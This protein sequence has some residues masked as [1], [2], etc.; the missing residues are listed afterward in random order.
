[1]TKDEDYTNIMQACSNIANH[2]LSGVNIKRVCVH[3][4]RIGRSL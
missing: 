1:M 3:D 4:T 2:G